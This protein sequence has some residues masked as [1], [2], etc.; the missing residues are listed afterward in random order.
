MV[1]KEELRG[2]WGLGRQREGGLHR[3]AP[4][5]GDRARVAV[6]AGKGAAGDGYL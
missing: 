1:H 3:A 6:H 2:L 4:M 5:A